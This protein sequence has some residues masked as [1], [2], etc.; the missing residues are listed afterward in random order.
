MVPFS[1]NEMS[2]Y[3]KV[4]PTPIVFWLT[5]SLKS[6]PDIKIFQKWNNL[7]SH[8]QI[9]NTSQVLGCILSQDD[10]GWVQALGGPSFLLF[11]LEDRHSG[12]GEENCSEVKY[13]DTMSQKLYMQKLIVI[14][15]FKKLCQTQ[16]LK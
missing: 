6:L 15:S 3:M 1:D 5:Y 9:Y 12:Q 10:I 16:T 14:G 2:S 8:G 7:A 11:H 13:K 4:V